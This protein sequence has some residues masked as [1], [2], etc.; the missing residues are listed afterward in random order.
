MVGLK[1]FKLYDLAYPNEVG[2]PHPG[3]PACADS[4][5]C[6]GMW[7]WYWTGPNPQTPGYE[8]YVTEV[9]YP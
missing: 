4:V 1:L 9:P 7:S 8:Q 2:V 6:N 3:S 5:A